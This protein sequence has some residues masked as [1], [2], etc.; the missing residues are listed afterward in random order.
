MVRQTL[1][2]CKHQSFQNDILFCLIV[3]SLNFLWL[4]ITGLTLKQPN[5]LLPT[6]NAEKSS[7]NLGHNNN[8]SKERS[9]RLG[10]TVVSVLLGSAV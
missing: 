2:K 8:F 5:K 4:F 6:G 3:C 1:F 7:I 9:G 10:M